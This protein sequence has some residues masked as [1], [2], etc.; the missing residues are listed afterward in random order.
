[1]WRRLLGGTIKRCSIRLVRIH[2]L[3]TEGVRVKWT[4]RF[5]TLNNQG[6]KLNCLGYRSEDWS[7]FP[8]QVLLANIDL[9]RQIR[10]ILSENCFACHGL[11]DLWG[12][13]PG[14]FNDLYKGGRV[15]ISCH[16]T[17]RLG[18]KVKFTSTW[19]LERGGASKG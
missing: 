18:K 13:L 2:L 7:L 11:D 3:S 10:P 14:L 5:C 6:I 15:W 4:S 16:R 19:F 17:R 8:L 1:M 12:G 9:F